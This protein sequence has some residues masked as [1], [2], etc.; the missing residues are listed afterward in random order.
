MRV[1]ALPT[2]FHLVSTVSGR[3]RPDVDLAALLR[4]PDVSWYLRQE[5]SGLLLEG[6][7]HVAL[8]EEALIHDRPGDAHRIQR[9]DTE[10]TK[11]EMA[12][13]RVGH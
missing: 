9:E 3:L 4:D 6:G 1:M 2:V 12:H 10:R 11:T 8:V 5:R 7:R 13:R